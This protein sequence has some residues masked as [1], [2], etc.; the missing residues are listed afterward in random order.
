MNKDFIEC[1]YGE[2]LTPEQEIESLNIAIN[3]LRAELKDLNEKIKKVYIVKVMS[4]S[5]YDLVVNDVCGFFTKEEAD[6]KCKELNSSYDIEVDLN[7]YVNAEIYFTNEFT[8]NYKENS[9]FLED[10]DYRIA[11]YSNPLYKESVNFSW[12][13]IKR[14]YAK[15]CKDKEDIEQFMHKIMYLPNGE[16]SPH[17]NLFFANWLKCF[18]PNIDK[19][20]VEDIE[21]AVKLYQETWDKPVA[22]VKE[23]DIVTK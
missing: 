14:M 19:Y 22:Y 1:P 11:E 4:G 23:I 7:D 21:E 20:K 6:N 9:K 15:H 12:T 18:G 2:G 17:Y 16:K 8:D 10:L 3:K 13:W 5:G